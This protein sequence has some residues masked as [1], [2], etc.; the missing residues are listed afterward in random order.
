MCTLV[1]G[2]T[3]VGV[4]SMRENESK[5]LL[6]HV[7]FWEFSP[8]YNSEWMINNFIYLL[9][10]ISTSVFV[11]LRAYLLVTFLFSLLVIFLCDTFV[12]FSFVIFVV[13]CFCVLVGSSQYSIRCNSQKSRVFS[14]CLF[15]LVFCLP[16]DQ[17]LLG[18]NDHRSPHQADQALRPGCCSTRARAPSMQSFGPY[19][20]G[21]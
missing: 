20:L 10:Y 4:M 1:C 7:D 19:S 2:S 8:G 6:T 11:C 12:V 5:L 16:V 14:C 9:L 21:D 3:Q 15:T 13:V 18:S 17:S